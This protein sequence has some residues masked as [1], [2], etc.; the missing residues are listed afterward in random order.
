MKLNLK[1]KG[2]RGSLNEERIKA[3]GWAVTGEI[4]KINMI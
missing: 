4:I 3:E 1:D 2:S